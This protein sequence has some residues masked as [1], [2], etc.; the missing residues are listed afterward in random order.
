MGSIHTH[1]NYNAHAYASFAI[2]NWGYFI[3]YNIKL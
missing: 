1:S 2:A 3:I